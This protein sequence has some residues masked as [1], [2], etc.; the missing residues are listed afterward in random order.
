MDYRNI[1][2]S[3]KYL[4][5]NGITL[6]VDERMRVQLALGQLQCEIPF[7]EL[8]LWGKIEGKSYSSI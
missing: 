7:E 8:M 5:Q 6:N 3:I 2:N 1:N 4:A